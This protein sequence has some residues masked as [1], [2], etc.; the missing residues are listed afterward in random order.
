MKSNRFFIL[1]TIYPSS[2]L[3]II[4]WSVCFNNYHKIIILLHLKAVFF[5]Y[6]LQNLLYKTLVKHSSLNHFWALFQLSIFK[7]VLM[8]NILSYSF[9]N[10]LGGIE[11]VDN[12][13]FW[14]LS[15]LGFTLLLPHRNR[16]RLND[17]K[18]I[19]KSF[20]SKSNFSIPSNL[21]SLLLRS[22]SI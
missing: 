15:K 16:F 10:I 8:L 17:L 19:H 1:S 22:L 12:L 11:K 7:H 9:R 3:I 20:T 13:A 6:F 2:L 5:S 18:K 4:C 21:P 14:F